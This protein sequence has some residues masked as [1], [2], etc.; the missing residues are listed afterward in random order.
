MRYS[1]RLAVCLSLALA[2]ISLSEG[3]IDAAPITVHI[4]ELDGVTPVS[5]VTQINVYKGTN[6]PSNPFAY[7]IYPTSPSGTYLIPD[8]GPLLANDTDKTISIVPIR[9]N[10]IKIVKGLNGASTASS[11]VI[12]VT[13]GP[14]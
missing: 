1:Q 3:R 14:F 9:G 7:L 13:I 6:P 10:T 4:F 11:F 8:L 12:D 2:G 5:N